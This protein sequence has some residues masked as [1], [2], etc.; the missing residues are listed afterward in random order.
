MSP[1]C[2]THETIPRR[3]VSFLSLY[4]HLPT[5]GRWEGRGTPPARL[6]ASPVSQ[7]DA[8]SAI[9]VRR[10]AAAEPMVFIDIDGEPFD[11]EVR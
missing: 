6:K 2:P 8:A 3:P 4:A 10:T 7:A 9:W 11:G 1:G 5:D